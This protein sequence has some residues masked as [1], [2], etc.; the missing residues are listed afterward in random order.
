MMMNAM[1]AALS[2]VYFS[3]TPTLGMG[4]S[5]LPADHAINTMINCLP[6][7]PNSAAYVNSIGSV[8]NLH[9]DFSAGQWMGADIGIPFVEVSSSQASYPATFLYA[10]ESD[11]GMY[12]IPLD[13]PIEGGSNSTGDRHAI[14]LD[15][16]RCLLYELYNAYPNKTHS[17][18]KADSGV[19]ANL[20]S[21]QLRPADW[22]SSDA[23]G[24]LMFP[25]LVRYEEVL[26]GEIKHAIRFTAPKTQSKYVWPARHEASDLADTVYPP[27]GQRFRLKASFNISQ[28]SAKN[29][30]IL[31]A[32]KRYGIILAD[33]GSP[34]YI[35]GAPNLGWNDDDLRK[36]RGIVG[37]DF[38]AVDAS[39]LMQN[40]SSGQAKQI[41]ENCGNGICNASVGETL[42]TCL[43]DCCRKAG[44]TCAGPDV[45]CS[46]KCNTKTKKCF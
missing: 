3:L 45:C 26:V 35:S 29:Q 24:V 16:E 11:A 20:A 30:V 38:E 39:Y 36:L 10:S 34:W 32:M 21:Y 22:T 41:C 40:I 23:A 37:Q 17:R 7:H 4:C 44:A 46:K 5:I 43:A 2:V 28:F 19:V 1:K 6:V 14:A 8:A 31:R 18:W 12:A 9:P 13:A 25:S 27:M 33:N 15:R 42:T